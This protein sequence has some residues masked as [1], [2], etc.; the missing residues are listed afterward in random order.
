MGETKKSQQKAKRSPKTLSRTWKKGLS[1]A[2]KRY[3]LNKKKTKEQ[4][5]DEF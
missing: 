5:I 1:K 3:Y 4:L 2:V